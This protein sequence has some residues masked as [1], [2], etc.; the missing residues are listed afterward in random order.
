MVCHLSVM[1]LRRWVNMRVIAQAAESRELREAR[2][3][4]LEARQQ[5]AADGRSKAAL[6]LES[7]VSKSCKGG[8]AGEEGGSKG[9]RRG[10]AWKGEPGQLRPEIG[11]PRH[12]PAES[13]YSL[14]QRSSRIGCPE[15]SRSMMQYGLG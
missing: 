13:S 1:E 14:W 12:S 10:S 2:D 3:N 8:E 15:C 4:L 6:Q 9:G 11:L 5:E 7:A